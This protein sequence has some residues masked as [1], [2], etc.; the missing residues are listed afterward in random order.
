MPG[1]RKTPIPAEQV[2]E[3]QACTVDLR[4]EILSRAPFFAGLSQKEIEAINPLFREMGFQAGQTILHSG[5]PAERLCVIA[6]GKVKLVR[7]SLT[8]KDVLLDIL[9][10]GEFFGSLAVL[11]DET[12]PDTAQAQTDV[13]VLGIDSDAFRSV[14]EKH[15][16]VALRVLDV[17][18]G[19]LRSAHEMV[20]QLSAYPVEQR[21]AYTL[22]KLAEKLGKPGEVGLLIEVPLSRDELAE[23]TGAT[24]ETASRVISQFQKDGLIRAGRQWVAIA[25]PQRLR[26]AAG[27]AQ[28]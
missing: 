2:P 19:R 12:Y 27:E 24:T 9:T 23:M 18:A 26:E 28:D 22:L 20:R 13:C 8:G 3:P 10:P 5:D 7:H 17:M 16:A 21:I 15:P 4:L 11:G 1:R 14:L 25:D 6:A